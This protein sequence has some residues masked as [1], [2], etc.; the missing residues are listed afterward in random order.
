MGITRQA[1]RSFNTAGALRVSKGDTVVL[2]TENIQQGMTTGFNQ[3]TGAQGNVPLVV[4]EPPTIVIDFGTNSI[5]M[6]YQNNHEFAFVL[7]SQ[8]Q[9]NRNSR[10][11]WEGGWTSKSVAS[12]RI[13]RG[14]KHWIRSDAVEDS[15]FQL[16]GVRAVLKDSMEFHSELSSHSIHELLEE[17]FIQL[18]VDAE[19]FV[20]NP[21]SVL[22]IVPHKWTYY[23]RCVLI[24]SA[25]LAHFYN[26]ELQSQSVSFAYRLM[27]QERFLQPAVL[28]TMGSSWTEIALLSSNQVVNVVGKEFGGNAFTNAIFQHVLQ[29]YPIEPM[30]HRQLF[31]DCENAKK[32][33]SERTSTTI[34]LPEGEME[35]NRDLMLSLCEVIFGELRAMVNQL[36]DECGINQFQL[37]AGCGGGLKLHSLQDQIQIWFQKELV[38]FS[39]DALVRG[40]AYSDTLVDKPLH[41][42]HPYSIGVNTP[43]GFMEPIIFEKSVWP[44]GNEIHFLAEFGPLCQIELYEGSF[45]I[46]RFN[47][48]IASIQI[49]GNQSMIPEIRKLK[50]FRDAHGILQVLVCDPRGMI[51][52]TSFITDPFTIEKIQSKRVDQRLLL[53]RYR[54]ADEPVLEW[55]APAAPLR[56]YHPQNAMIDYHNLWLQSLEYV[57]LPILQQLHVSAKR[58]I[59]KRCNLHAKVLRLLNELSKISAPPIPMIEVQEAYHESFTGMIDRFVTKSA[60]V[61]FS[62][63]AIA[64]WP[65]LMD[66][67][68]DYHRLLQQMMDLPNDLQVVKEYLEGLLTR[69]VDLLSSASELATDVEADL[70]FRNFVD[71]YHSASV[72][73]LTLT[74]Q[75]FSIPSTIRELLHSHVKLHSEFFKALSRPIP[76]MQFDQ[77]HLVVELNGFRS[78]YQLAHEIQARITQEHHAVFGTA[79]IV[80]NNRVL[81]Q[82]NKELYLYEEYLLKALIT[83][84]GI[85]IEGNQNLRVL[86]K[87]IV[88]MCQY[89]LDQLDALKKFYVE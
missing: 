84:D 81:P 34:P 24:Q 64:D 69:M 67:L 71:E 72:E 39:E 32:E 6:G 28:I 77:A 82:H 18:R 25:R 79:I 31:N 48:K 40:A 5:R 30:H 3:T 74:D 21:V 73:I 22:I 9:W 83:L 33:L 12:N 86:R 56:A 16:V 63:S 4:F 41:S 57:Q 23:Q 61:E 50:L 14:I 44:N 13:I 52:H 19:R 8:G 1:Q 65:M 62:H 20:P 26:V 78:L 37:V 15:Y 7:N 43:S 80:T 87:D 47:H 58:K 46:S 42:M 51:M 45:S 36:I 49:E 59:L 76:S 35:L 75:G 53:H 88:N 27:Q 68:R 2:A 54:L 38:Y 70:K 10:L 85:D 11:A 66:E 29:L 89:R 60:E 17:L 55:K